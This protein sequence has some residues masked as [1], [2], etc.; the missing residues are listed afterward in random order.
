MKRR[1]TEVTGEMA[2]RREIE[3]TW[4]ELAARAEEFQGCRLK[5]I[6]LSEKDPTPPAAPE[7]RVRKLIAQWQRQDRSLSAAPVQRPNG[8]SQTEALFRKWSEEDAVL[9][10]EER[11][12]EEQFWADFQRSINAERTKIGMRTLF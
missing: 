12:N 5:L 9:T 1:E 10:D 8:V 3:G 4:E 2:K 11:Q 6:V 7:E